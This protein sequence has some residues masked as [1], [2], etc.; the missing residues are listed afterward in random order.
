MFMHHTRAS[1]K[2]TYR[3]GEKLVELTQELGLEICNTSFQKP[4]SKLLE[5]SITK[6]RQ[7]PARL[8]FD[9]ENMEKQRQR[10]PGIQQLC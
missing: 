9:T 1:H 7:V 3:N 10:C 8:Y 5:S 4:K 2:E 6:R